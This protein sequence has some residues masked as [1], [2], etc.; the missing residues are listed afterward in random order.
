M[1]Y[2]DLTAELPLIPIGHALKS[3]RTQLNRIER[4]AVMLAKKDR[5][6]S[7]RPI[8]VLRKTAGRLFGLPARNRLADP[9]LEAL[10]RFAVAIAHDTPARSDD[11]ADALRTL[12]FTSGQINRAR[13]IAEGFR[14]R[15]SSGIG[16]LAVIPAIL[17]PGTWFVDHFLGDVLMS[18]VTAMTIA[19]PIWT[20]LT[21]RPTRQG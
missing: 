5:R 20:T 17:L 7:I 21:P 2:L 12:G 10:R 16:Q 18:A 1:A 19:L 14:I 11:E 4:E 6:S 13:A 8:G 9:R 3:E 15:R